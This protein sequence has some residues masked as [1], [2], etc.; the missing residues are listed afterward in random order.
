[1][2]LILSRK[3]FDSGNAGMPS[4]VMPDGTPLS[5]P[6]PRRRGYCRSY[7]DLLFRGRTLGAIIRE[8]AN[9]ALPFDDNAHADPDLDEERLPRLRGWRP[10]FGQTGGDQTHLENEGVG[11][12]DIFL[13]F[14][15]FRHATTTSDGRLRFAQPRD[16]FHAIFGWLEVG[17]VHKVNR[18]S[19]KGLPE[20]A[21]DHPHVATPDGFDSNNTIYVSSKNLRLGGVDLPIPGGGSFGH[22][23]SALRLPLSRVQEPAGRSRSGFIPE[24]TDPRSHITATWNAGQSRERSQFLRL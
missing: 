17:E 21:Q 24:A 2:K 8:L 4:P 3:G 1:M 23:S 14:G 10:I 20:W 11:I 6:I 22:F 7:D 12:G 16:D 13:F 15:W 19:A 5:L 9:G 18:R